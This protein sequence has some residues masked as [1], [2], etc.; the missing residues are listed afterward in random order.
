VGLEVLDRA[1][2]KSA[3]ESAGHPQYTGEISRMCIR[4]P[5]RN[6]V[7]A[8]VGHT[9]FGSNERAFLERLAPSAHD[10]P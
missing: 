2:S 1:D 10:L 3:G 5:G 9:N 8:A 7:V 6:R 4:R